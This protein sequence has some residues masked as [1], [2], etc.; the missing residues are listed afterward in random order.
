M[1]PAEKNDVPM[2]TIGQ[3]VSE[4]S[5]EYSDITHSSLR[6]LEREGFIFPERTPGGHRLFPPDQLD[7]IRLIKNWQ[8]QRLSLDEIKVRLAAADELPDLQRIAVQLLAFL[9]SGERDDARKLILDAYDAGVTVEDLFDDVF[10]PVL[11]ETGEKWE[12]GELAVGQEKEISFFLRDLIAQ[13]GAR[14][15]T[16]AESTG[17]TVIAACV[18]GESHELGLRMIATLLRAHGYTV[19]Y[20]GPNVSPAFLVERIAVRQPDAVLIGV[21]LS[22]NLVSLNQSL[23]AIRE[24]SELLEKPLVI[25]G[26]AGVP[27]DWGVPV[28]SEISLLAAPTMAEIVDEIDHLITGRLQSA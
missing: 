9:I 8:Q 16:E 21:A 27:D 20:L 7:R 25:V 22:E 11:Y 13:I 5:T 26:G 4:L 2:R 12:T 23:L 18:E 24:A 28:D 17:P 10:Q 6:F 14:S 3:V 19:Y 15:Q 1:A